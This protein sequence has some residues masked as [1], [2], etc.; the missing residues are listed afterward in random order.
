M[1]V[2]GE[3]RPDPMVAL[4]RQSDRQPSDA[5]TS[6]ANV[7]GAARRWLRYA[8]SSSPAAVAAISPKRQSGVGQVA[9]ASRSNSAPRSNSRVHERR[10]SAPRTRTTA[11][12]LWTLPVREENV[13]RLPGWGRIP[14]LGQTLLI[15]AWVIE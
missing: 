13:S 3:R 1:L 14:V 5:G 12:N 11:T 2:S 6:K 8:W 7:R 4:G 9:A 10:G 15:P